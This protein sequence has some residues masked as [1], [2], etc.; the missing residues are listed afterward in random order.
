MY[1]GVLVKGFQVK[2]N[3]VQYFKHVFLRFLLSDFDAVSPSLGIW[4]S[5]L[6][7]AW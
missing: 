5:R 3:A 4:E 2:Y 6:K 1:F 7:Q